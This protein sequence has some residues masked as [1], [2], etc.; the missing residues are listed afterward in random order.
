M[1]RIKALCQTELALILAL[2]IPCYTA[3]DKALPL[4][5]SAPICKMDVIMSSTAELSSGINK[6]LYL[7]LAQHLAT[8]K[9]SYW[10]QGFTLSLLEC[11]EKGHP[12]LS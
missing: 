3:Q 8:S 7:G 5:L 6:V 4:N 10:P 2:S 11:A 12:T 9:G 1:S